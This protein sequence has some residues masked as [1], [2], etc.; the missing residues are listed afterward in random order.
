MSKRTSLSVS[1]SF[2]S[3]GF[4]MQ[5]RNTVI[6]Y[7]IGTVVF[8][9]AFFWLAVCR[10]RAAESTEGS[11][12]HVHDSTCYTQ[13]TY[14]CGRN[15]YVMQRCHDE[16]VM[17][18]YACDAQVTMNLDFDKMYCSEANSYWYVNGSTVCSVCGT[19]RTNWG[20]PVG[21]HTLTRNRLTCGVG[22]GECVAK[23]T[24][25]APEEWTKEGVT[26]SAF[27]ELL[28]GGNVCAARS[29]SWE[30][31]TLYVTENGTYTVEAVNGLGQKTTASYTVSCI[32]RTPLS[33]RRWREIR[34]P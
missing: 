33:L 13:E 25:T 5:K 28:K 10:V 29:Y 24:I 4:F 3:G 7:G 26:L 9:C 11:F 22:D 12:I 19:L 15:H 27:C 6:R 18:C 30:E 23:V 2:G 16:Q 17:H 14:E 32:D 20:S 21:Y 31:G 8:G 34:R 1:L